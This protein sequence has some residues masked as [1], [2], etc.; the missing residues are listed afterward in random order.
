MKY[1]LVFFF[2]FIACLFS[3]CRKENKNDCG[4]ISVSYGG[5]TYH[6]IEINGQCWFRE[7]IDIGIKVDSS[8]GQVENGTVEKHC[9]GNQDEHCMTF[10]GLYMWDEMMQ[11]NDSG[12]VQ[13]I[14][15]DGWHVPSS[16]EWDAMIAFLGGDGVAGGKMKETGTVHWHNPNTA[17]NSS[18][19]SALPGGARRGN[20]SF[21]NIFHVGYFWSSTSVS[22][23]GGVMYS[24]TSQETLISKEYILKSYSAS[25]R[26]VKN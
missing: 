20:T 16:D 4:K 18:G 7:N 6:T 11:Y 2:I 1:Y 25:V 15:P 10:G 12:I 24:L 17:D 8:C 23:S 14:C 19:F 22:T 3:S 21:M 5:K 9:Y 13:G 26:C